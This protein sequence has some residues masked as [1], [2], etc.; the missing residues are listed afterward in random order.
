MIP[1]KKNKVRVRFAPSPTGV[2]HLGTARTAL[3]NFLFARKNGGKYILR[4]EDTDTE[5]SRKEFEQNIIESLDWLNIHSDEVFRQSDRSDI[6][7]SHLQKLIEGGFAYLSKELSSELKEEGSSDKRSEV[8]RF[9]NP[10]KTVSFKDEIRGPIEF[11]TSELGDFVIAK[12]LDEPLYHLAVVVDDYEMDITHV[13]RGEDH[14]SNTPRQILIQEAIG[15]PRPQYFHL[16][17]ILGKDRSKLSKRHGALPVLEYREMG[18]LPEAV[19]NY[20]ALLGWSPSGEEDVFSPAQLAEA[21]NVN[22]FQKSPA[23]FSDEKLEWLNRKHISYLNDDVLEKYVRLYIDPSAISAENN[24]TMIR[25]LLPL[26]RER[27]SKF[28]DLKIYYKEE[29]EFYF[30][31][32]EYET[33]KLIP[34]K[35]EGDE[36][37]KIAKTVE[38]LTYILDVLRSFSD[39][40]V[41]ASKIKEQLWDY[42]TEKGRGAVL[43]PMRYALSGREKSPDP[44]SLVEILGLKESIARIADAIVRLNK[45]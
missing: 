34:S 37:T 7:R 3:F 24:E 41:I 19:V 32:P 17:L 11:D 29:F 35:S 45:E 18:Y 4:I 36:K 40:R 1:T 27:I 8:I 12:S 26:I 20:L 2:V 15:A 9:R 22:S 28:S 44:F 10:N 31:R 42:A 13:I 23:V 5:R 16:P 14:I 43:W 30:K 38:Y 21:F 33:S 25:R 39:D 6:Y